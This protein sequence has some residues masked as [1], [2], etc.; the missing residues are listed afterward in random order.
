MRLDGLADMGD[1][2]VL[3]VEEAAK[4]LRIGRNAAYASARQWRK[5]NGREGLPVIVIG[6]TLR[7]P[8]AVLQEMLRRPAPA[9]ERPALTIDGRPVRRIGTSR[10]A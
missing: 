10:R 6:R 7:V 4:V 8:V 3:T 1:E 9:P 5:T 2:A